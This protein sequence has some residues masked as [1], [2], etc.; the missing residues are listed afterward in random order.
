MEWEG[1][2]VKGILHVVRRSGKT[3]KNGKERETR[4]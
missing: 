3:E 4:S 2:F 1:K